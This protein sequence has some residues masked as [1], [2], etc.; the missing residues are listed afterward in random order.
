MDLK[1]IFNPL[2]NNFDTILN[3]EDCL[4]S[5]NGY[6]KFPN[7]LILQWGKSTVNV[8][9]AGW[10]L[11]VSVTFPVQFPNEVFHISIFRDNFN[12]AD[13]YVHDRRVHDITTSSFQYD[14]DASG[15]GTSGSVNWYWLAIGY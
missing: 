12:T 14:F 5:A 2:I 10:V 1:K 15:V 8:S 9:E 4:I 11:D 7:G 13:L 6:V 3:F